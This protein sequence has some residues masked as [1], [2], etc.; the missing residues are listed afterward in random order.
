MGEE[1]SGLGSKLFFFSP[2]N[3]KV[4]EHDLVSNTDSVVLKSDAERRI[5]RIMATPPESIILPSE[6]DFYVMPTGF[7]A[8]FTCDPPGS[9]EFE[10][11]RDKLLG[12]DMPESLRFDVHV[13]PSNHRSRRFSDGFRLPR[14][15]KKAM[16]RGGYY[17]RNTKWKRKAIALFNRYPEQSP[18]MIGKAKIETEEDGLVCIIGGSRGGV[19][20]EVVNRK[21]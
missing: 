6:G 8:S 1:F 10:A 9:A 3:G 7:S 16:I 15:I 21:Q 14:R 2:D 13:I 19:K 12:I 17:M 5:D 20:N 4:V 11:I 18:F